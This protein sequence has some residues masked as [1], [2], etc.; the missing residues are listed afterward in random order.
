MKLIIENLSDNIVTLFRR[1]G[2]TFQREEKGEMSF[3]RPLGRSGY[4]RFHCYTK[5]HGLG[6]ECNLHLDQKRETYGRATRHH[7]E[8][9]EAGAL[10]EELLRMESIIGTLTRV[11]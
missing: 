5:P 9:E 3:V 1:A 10:A 2:F 8:Y 6:I 7:G 11:V 4:P